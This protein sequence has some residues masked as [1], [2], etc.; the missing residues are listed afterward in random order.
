M[1]QN[2]PD[3]DMAPGK[4]ISKYRQEKSQPASIQY[5]G[6][7]WNEEMPWG[8]IGGQYEGKTNYKTKP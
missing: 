3:I 2:V 1:M 4:V 5:E 8:A 6:R 7:E